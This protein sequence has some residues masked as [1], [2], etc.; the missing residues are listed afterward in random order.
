MP[1]NPSN[2]VDWFLVKSAC[3]W[4]IWRT[5]HCSSFSVQGWN[6]F[7]RWKNSTPLKVGSSNSCLRLACHFFARTKIQHLKDL[8]ISICWHTQTV[9]YVD[10]RWFR[11]TTFGSNSGLKNTEGTIS[12]F[13]QCSR[14]P[15]PSW[16]WITP[17]GG[18]TSPNTWGVHTLVTNSTRC[19]EVLCLEPTGAIG[20]SW[21]ISIQA[22]RTW[23]GGVLV[24][25]VEM[26]QEFVEKGIWHVFCYHLIWFICKSIRCNSY[27]SVTSCVKLGWSTLADCYWLGWH[28]QAYSRNH[29][30]YCG[31]SEFCSISYCAFFISEARTWG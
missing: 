23:Q 19:L 25:Q 21:P 9:V 10:P 26:T 6:N 30:W 16:C 1:K 4:W 14:W 2:L 7:L 20:Y 29:W 15:S 12:P 8:G 11:D 13:N 27:V 28:S 22:K 31:W 17:A 5:S 3:R 24:T 18:V